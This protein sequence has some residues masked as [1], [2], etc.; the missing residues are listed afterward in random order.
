MSL[1]G[2][3]MEELSTALLD[4]YDRSSLEQLLLFRLDQRLDKFAPAGGDMRNTVFRIIECANQEGWED[5][6]IAA[7]QEYIPGNARMAAFREK[8]LGRR[9]TTPPPKPE[10]S[11]GAIRQP[12]FT[13]T[14]LLEIDDLLR[15]AELVSEESLQALQ[16][17]MNR[18]F[19]ASLPTMGAVKFRLLN[20]LH[21]LNGTG[22]LFGGEVPFETFL[23]NAAY[24]A[25]PRP[26]AEA[27]ERLRLRVRG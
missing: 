22:E 12:I 2:K 19:R 14:E 20:I 3:Q 23:A 25:K 18:D 26:E 27:F 11:R 4:A 5:Q 9:P 10:S 6:L 7:A 16:G 24:L 13:H 1:N 15:S 21:I 17:G 8:Y